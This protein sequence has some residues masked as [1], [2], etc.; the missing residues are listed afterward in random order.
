MAKEQAPKY[1]SLHPEQIKTYRPP[2]DSV[3]TW[4]RVTSGRTE[5]LLV[6][7]TRYQVPVQ[8]LV[9]LNFPGSLDEH[10][11]IVP[12]IV[13]WYLHHHNG[14][15]CPE[16][17]DRQNRI[18]RGGERVAIPLLGRIALGDPIIQ[19]KRP[20]SLDDKYQWLG[21]E[22]FFHEW[23]FPRTGAKE[24]GYLAAQLRLMIEGEI[25]ETG[26]TKLGVSVQQVKATLDQELEK[27]F[28]IVYGVR[29]EASTDDRDGTME[30][31]ADGFRKGNVKGIA[32]ALLAPFS[33][34]LKQK[35]GITKNFALVPEIALQAS[36]TPVIGR[37]TADFE[38]PL[39]HNLKI[40]GIVRGGLHVGLS[41]KGLAWLLEKLGP[42]AIKRFAAS[43]GR[44]FSGL[45]EY[46]VAEGIVAGAA[47][48]AVAVVAAFGMTYLMACILKDTSQ[49]G[50]MG[51]LATWYVE[52]YVAK[53]FHTAIVDQWVEKPYQKAKQDLIRA[54][55]L[56]AVADARN[57]LRQ[58]KLLRQAGGTE[59]EALAA[60]CNILKGTDS[61]KVAKDRL[62]GL[63]TERSRKIFGL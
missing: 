28:K 45:W 16:T 51:G 12:E 3:L 61:E 33:V 54:G 56:D 48:V 10:G 26:P 21:G 46:M 1:A 9:E 30:R 40:K 60:Y 19:K 43:A 31:M 6:L 5:N 47:V 37:L 55:E 63:L 34:A 2:D 22:K 39:A 44:A 59:D 8:K 15:Q 36:S 14:F 42:E 53:V 57:F 20:I 35:Y 50:M 7:A 25:A 18:F 49:K 29:V 4:H 13:N 58:Q 41:K 27:D 52:G 23:R 62:R 11:R 24:Y 32:G 38:Y 17:H